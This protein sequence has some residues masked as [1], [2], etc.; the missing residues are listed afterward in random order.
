MRIVVVGGGI[1]G[2]ATAHLLTSSV[3]DA[4]VVVV[5]KEAGL[6]RHQTGRNSGVAHAGLYY[7]P[8]S[9][10]ATLCRRGI[11]M[12]RDFCR[13]RELPYE[14][15]GKVV[16]ATEDRE[17]EPLHRLAERAAANGVPGLRWLQTGELSEVEPHVRG[18][19]G[20]HSPETAIV[21]FVAVADALAAEVRQAG[22]EIR[23]GTQVVRV[24]GHGTRPTVELEDGSSLQ[25]DR[26]VVCAGLQA[27]R[28]ARASGQTAEPRIV[29]FRGEY[30]Q[31]RADRRHLVRGL[32]YPVPDPTLPFLGVHLTLKIDGAVW[33]GPNA[34]LS[35]ARERYGRASVNLRDVYDTASWPG[36]RRMMRQH[37][38]AGV[39]ELARS[40]RKRLFIREVQR[41]VPA[42]TPDDAV[43]APA[44]IRAQAI[45]RD[46]SLVD[47]FRLSVTDG[48]VWV[49]NAPSPAATSSMAIAEELVARALS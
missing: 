41:Y 22:G 1:L 39:G 37:W 11:V 33:L 2:L 6:A 35:L 38:R 12:L 20:L 24:L 7:A 44:G 13:A 31:L 8:G 19:A 21:D 48:V 40:A 36:T 42:L 4:E 28:L 47:A 29:P 9:L 27:D 5:E 49:R 17:L 34:V 14:E 16:V 3:A 15:C 10:K 23:T 18:L 25:A 46:G 30:W 32:I 43:R 45:D 26:V